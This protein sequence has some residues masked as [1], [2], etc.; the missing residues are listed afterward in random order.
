MPGLMYVLQPTGELPLPPAETISEFRSTLLDIF[1]REF[2]KA[3]SDRDEANTSRFFKLFPMIA[4]E[5]EGLDAY[6][7]FVCSIV[8]SRSKGSLQQQASSPTFFASLLTPL[9][10]QIAH[11]ISQHQPVV[12]KYYG[13]KRMLPV[14]GK[15]QE[16]CDKQAGQ[17]LSQWEEE[18]RIARKLQET[19]RYRYPQLAALAQPVAQ[20]SQAAP[21]AA[22]AALK[23]PYQQLSRQ[24]TQSN[25]A[26][27]GNATALE[28]EAIDPREIDAVL[29]EL[30]QMS[31]RWQLYRR[32]MYGRLTAEDEDTTP[33]RR[34]IAS[35]NL[36][37]SPD[38]TFSAPGA[39]GLFASHPAE[40]AEATL[41][42]VEESTF[43]QSLQKQLE[44]AYEPLEVWYL[45][46]SI[47]RAH[48]LDEPDLSN[49]PYLSSSLD[50]T[51]FILK[52][53][54]LRLVTCANI[55]THVK[56]CAQTRDVM[57]R[58]F[59][60][61]L[62]KRMDAVWASLTGIAAN[63]RAKEEDRART[64]FIVSCVVRKVSCCPANCHHAGLRERPGDGSRLHCSCGRGDYRIGQ[65]NAVV[66]P[67]K[68][69]RPSCQR[70]RNR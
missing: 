45:R 50:D 25:L 16:E 8:S 19:G 32:F 67:Y 41:S 66:F 4:A 47:E 48:T 69:I 53:V 1:L 22:V 23:R 2:E 42:I 11:I 33:S 65:S 54:L 26:P 13:P 7:K 40:K 63:T 57:D 5:Q 58:D 59:G 68:R 35:P 51:F 39:A 34:L 10:E 28:D 44:T 31:G 12:E 70:D 61:I 55:Q 46:S 21:V 15:L 38:A 9:F 18:R 49:K 30:S 62:R 20:T 14:A 36:G 27:T 24:G 60:E 29:T 64:N 17:I 6:A 52:K 3:S 56:A 37:E 43:R